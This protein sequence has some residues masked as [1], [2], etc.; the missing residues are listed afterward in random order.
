MSSDEQGA[1]GEELARERSNIANAKW[2]FDYD[3]KVLPVTNLF[4][5]EGEAT[6]D[7]VLACSCVAYD[8]E[9]KH[10]NGK[11][12]CFGNLEPGEVWRKVA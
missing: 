12:L 4:D 6:N 7:H 10:P 5:S 2:V 3:G 11:W 9:S 8:A 1:V